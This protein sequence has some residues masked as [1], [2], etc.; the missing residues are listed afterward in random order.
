MTEQELREK[1]KNVLSDNMRWQPYYAIMRGIVYEQD[2]DNL[3]DALI[4]A[5]IGDVSEYKHR[6]EKAERA[7]KNEIKLRLKLTNYSEDAIFALYPMALE[8]AEKELQ[9]EKER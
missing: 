4:A 3:A 7:L 5:G 9:E 2:L 6:A 8:E 1:I